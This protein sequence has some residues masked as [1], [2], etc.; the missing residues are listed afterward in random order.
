MCG[1]AL[2]LLGGVVGAAPVRAQDV[3]VEWAA[4]A[5]PADSVLVFNAYPPSDP[6]APVSA[7]YLTWPLDEQ[8]QP[9]ALQAFLDGLATTPR[10]RQ[11]LAS[12]LDLAL[13]QQPPGRRAWALVL[14]QLRTLETVLDRGGLVRFRELSE[15]LQHLYAVR[16][17]PTEAD[18][19]FPHLLGGY[20]VAY[21]R[22]GRLAPDGLSLDFGEVEY[23]RTYTDTVRMANLGRLPVTVTAAEDQGWSRGFTGPVFTLAPG[24]RRAVP[25]TFKPYLYSRERRSDVTV[26]YVGGVGPGVVLHLSGGRQD[27]PIRI[28]AV[29]AHLWRNY[30]SY[31]VLLAVVGGSLVLFL[32]QVVLLA[33]RTLGGRRLPRPPRRSWRWSLPRPS[34]PAAP[35]IW[36]RAV[37]AFR[38]VREKMQA[39]AVRPEPPPPPRPAPVAVEARTR[40][41]GDGAGDA[42]GV[43][44]RR[45]SLRR[46]AAVAR[47]ALPRHAGRTIEPEPPSRPPPRETTSPEPPPAGTPSSDDLPPPSTRPP[48]PSLQEMPAEPPATEPSAAEPPAAEPPAAEPPAAEPP[49]VRLPLPEGRGGMPEAGTLEAQCLEELDAL[50]AMIP[51]GVG[52]HLDPRAVRRARRILKK[53]VRQ[54]DRDLKT[55]DVP[56][57]EMIEQRNAARNVR[58]LLAEKQVDK[59][60][61]LLWMDNLE[62]ALRG[63]TDWLRTDG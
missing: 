61:V 56:P 11:V 34:L 60:I 10:A 12:A 17:R 53:L 46:R 32:A 3:A 52:I 27:V 54:I 55:V 51:S 21:E 13:F 43:R 4:F 37:A 36:T 33:V 47:D 40:G 63:E 9:R 44:M 29:H 20:L 5:G 18:P 50:R 16:G 30:P 58:E 26:R 2:G 8:A 49:A 31:R 59:Q 42:D 45:E 1:L 24:E 6:A 23:T 48:G 38:A 7:L 14:A 35:A 15:A 57:I 19:R 41:V 39:P 28:G 62:A 25:I 22:D